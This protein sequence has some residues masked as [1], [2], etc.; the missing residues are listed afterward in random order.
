LVLAGQRLHGH[1]LRFV[2]CHNPQQA[3]RDTTHRD[4]ALTRIDAELARID[5]QRARD[6]NCPSTDKTSPSRWW[7]G[8]GWPPAR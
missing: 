4:E 7:A 2:I 8:C 5:A 1:D 6:A 3:E